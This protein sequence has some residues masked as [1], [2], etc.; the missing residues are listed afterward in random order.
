MIISKFAFTKISPANITYW[1]SLGYD[2]GPTG[3]RAG[4]N[5][6][7]R[8]KVSVS[9]LKPKSNINVACRCDQCSKKYI[10]RFSRH[11][12]FC[13]SCFSSNKMK[14]NT[15]GK[16][17]K[18]KEIPCMRGENHPRFNPE[19]KALLQ[20]GSRVRW[21]SEKTYE[22]N[23]DII[24]PQNHPRGRC[25]VPDAYQLDHIKSVKQCFEE[26]LTPEQCSAIDNLQIISWQENRQKWC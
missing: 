19:R 3:G 17:N 6:G 12:G 10:S 21:L 22:A 20:Y 25:G 9:E 7:T 23:K 5:T 14:G 24:N 1:K 8:L 2:T 18:G 11:N 13:Y 15:N 26:G 16:A 4:K